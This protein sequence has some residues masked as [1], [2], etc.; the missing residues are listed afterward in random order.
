ME[1]KIIAKVITTANM[2][3]WQIARD[4]C[5]EKNVMVIKSIA[6]VEI[7]REVMR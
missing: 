5:W 6:I 4:Q 7:L 1:C 3:I 2:K